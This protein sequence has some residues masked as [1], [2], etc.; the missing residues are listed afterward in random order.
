[1]IKRIILCLITIPFI[2]CTQKQNEDHSDWILFGLLFL[3]CP[4]GEQRIVSDQIIKN[5]II[6]YEL[7]ASGILLSYRTILQTELA[8]YPEN[9]T[10]KACASRIVLTQNLRRSDIGYVAA[11][12]DPLQGTLFLSVNGQAGNSDTNYLI[13]VIHHE[14]HHNAEYATY[15]NMRSADPAWENLNTPGFI[16]GSGG[17][18]AYFN[19]NIPWSALT[20]PRPGF[21][22]LY[23]TLSQEEDRAEIVSLLMGGTTYFTLFSGFCGQDEIVR[24]KARKVSEMLSNL[25]GTT[26]YWNDRRTG[27]SCQ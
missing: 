5:T 21:V 4:G 3:P 7:P 8:K 24:N 16:Y 18:E 19:P 23:S 27:T 20:N 14:L 15:R 25:S 11:F 26:G 9:Y 10:T 2:V 13:R 17:S 12:P 22:N 1:M 6:D